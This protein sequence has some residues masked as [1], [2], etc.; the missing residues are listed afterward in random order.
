MDL[1]FILGQQ[2]VDKHFLSIDYMP[3]LLFCPKLG[4]AMPPGLEWE[5]P[6]FRVSLCHGIMLS[7][8]IQRK[9]KTILALKEFCLMGEKTYKQLCRKELRTESFG[10]NLRE[11]A[12]TL[13]E[14]L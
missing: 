6:C 10:T 9:A 5:V 8:E 14:G 1:R 4:L 12:L 3:R 7:P 2:A 13:K 11:K